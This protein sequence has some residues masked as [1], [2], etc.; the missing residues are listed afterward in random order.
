MDEYIKRDDAILRMCACFRFTQ[1]MASRILEA[2][3]TADVV[4]R[5]LY[6]RALSDVVTL[7]VERKKTDTTNCMCCY[8]CGAPLRWEAD[9][10]FA[11]YGIDDQQG[12]VSDYSC[13]NC[14]T[15]YQIFKPFKSEESEDN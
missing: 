14:D 1:Q 4:P 6:Q 12:V 11:D 8:F 15:S 5:E 10:S 13:D 9:F 2:V 7:S 3:P